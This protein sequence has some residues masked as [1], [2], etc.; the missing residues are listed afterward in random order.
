MSREE[1]IIT[2]LN[3]LCIAPLEKDI[4]YS[5]EKKNWTTAASLVTFFNYA[6]NIIAH[7]TGETVS[8]IARRHHKTSTLETRM[9]IAA[10]AR[11]PTAKNFGAKCLLYSE[12]L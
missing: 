6:Q 9:G 1:R 11:I 2:N 5:K 8:Q 3:Q 10:D 12:N 7:L 4:K